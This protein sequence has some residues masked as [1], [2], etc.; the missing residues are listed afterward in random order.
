MD[1]KIDDL[2]EKVGGKIML[3]NL[4]VLKQSFPSAKGQQTPFGLRIRSAQRP[5][6]IRA[7]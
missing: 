6:S 7:A 1:L 4:E 2:L 3:R 5:K